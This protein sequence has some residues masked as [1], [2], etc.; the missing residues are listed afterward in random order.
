MQAAL[1]GGAGALTFLAHPSVGLAHQPPRGCVCTVC[2]KGPSLGQPCPMALP[3]A[4]ASQSG[5]WSTDVELGGRGRGA[6]QSKVCDV[7]TAVTCQAGG[8]A[9]SVGS[10]GPL[11]DGERGTEQVVWAARGFLGRT[12][13]LQ[14]WGTDV[15][16]VTEGLGGGAPW[17]GGPHPR[18]SLG[19]GPGCSPGFRW[20]GQAVAPHLAVPGTCS[21]G[22]W[23]ASEPTERT[24]HWGSAGTSRGREW[25]REGR[26]VL[27]DE[28][29][30]A[31]QSS[32]RGP[33]RAMGLTY[34]CPDVL[35]VPRGVTW[36]A[37]ERLVC[38]GVGP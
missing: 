24:G 12:W 20:T 13:G 21:E 10:G 3:K 19:L 15:A 6:E 4:Q 8:G 36:G 5:R 9:G 23:K 11:S 14:P 2:E 7:L 34:G 1:S 18:H 31:S 32:P 22:S 27:T 30:S 37:Q 25:G 17:G 29:S 28:R 26:W 35:E 16:G 38:T 33:V